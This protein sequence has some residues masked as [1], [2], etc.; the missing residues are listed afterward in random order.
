LIVH[1]IEESFL[2]YA[3]FEIKLKQF[4]RARTIFERGLELLKTAELL[5]AQFAAFEE[6]EGEIE[7]A[8]LLY[9]Y[10]IEN[11][12]PSSANELKSLFLKFE[13]R[14]GG[15]QHIED[16]LV[17]A[18]IT[19]YEAAVGAD[20]LDYDSW[21]ELCRLRETF[22]DVN[23]AR[24]T[25]DRVF[26]HPPPRKGEKKDWGKFVLVCLSFAIFEER[27][28]KSPENTR[29]VFHRLLSL[30][31]HKKFTF[32]R[33]W[34]LYAYFEIR[35]DNL[36]AARTILGH[37][38]GT[39]PRS[40]IFDAYIE[41]E[42][43]LRNEDR[44]RTLFQKFIE[45]IPSDLR[46]WVKFAQFESTHGNIDTA[47][48]LFEAAIESD[49]IDATELLWSVYIDFESKVGNVENVRSLYRRDLAGD[50]QIALWKG[51]I[52]LEADD[53]GDLDCARRLFDEAERSLSEK[54][55][56]RKQLREFRVAFERE[57]G[58]DETVSEAVA[59][60]PKLND[61][62]GTLIFPEEDEASVASLLEAAELWAAQRDS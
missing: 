12:P 30:I 15:R 23:M 26:A 13:K 7:R 6:K 45:T 8:R 34:V 32:S 57:F 41:I 9:K 5:I 10:G 51:W 53:C 44:V 49:A 60:L 39:C 48:R 19:Q 14:Y 29:G 62:D 54:R 27:I 28:A 2:R 3:D 18:R 40:G 50:N 24:Q 11:L 36:K 55:E 17:E 43:L 38:L 59:K 42:T 31:P 47:R 58:T 35:Q 33:V 56:D 4:A 52:L 37:A 20:P 25:Y 61:Q 1:P 16:A 21:F 22:S 46:A